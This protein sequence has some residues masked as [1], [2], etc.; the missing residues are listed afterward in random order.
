MRTALCP[1]KEILNNNNNA[2]NILDN[3]N[4]VNIDGFILDNNNYVIN[5]LLEPLIF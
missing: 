1:A 5:I 4:A 2:L 3:N